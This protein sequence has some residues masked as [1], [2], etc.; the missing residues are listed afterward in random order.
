MFVGEFLVIGWKISK[1]YLGDKCVVK[2]EKFKDSS[3][4]GLRSIW[5]PLGVLSLLKDEASIWH[6][7]TDTHSDPRRFQDKTP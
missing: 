3:L 5:F 4:V 6:I 2:A 1:S 7:Y